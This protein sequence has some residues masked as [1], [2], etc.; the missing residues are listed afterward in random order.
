MNKQQIL[1]DNEREYLT[2]CA[3]KLSELVQRVEAMHSGKAS[4]ADTAAAVE[5]AQF[6]LLGDKL[7]GC[8]ELA[9]RVY[10][11]FQTVD[12]IRARDGYTAAEQTETF[13]PE[14]K[15]SEV[16]KPGEIPFRRW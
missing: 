7:G 13:K 1:K 11:H 8:A 16:V 5:L 10:S 9:G 6:L 15:P 14:P 12:S 2:V 4:E 3:G